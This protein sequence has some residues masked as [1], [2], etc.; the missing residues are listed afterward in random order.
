MVLQCNQCNERFTTNF[1][2]YRHKVEKHSPVIG[3]VTKSESKVSPVSEDP[4]RLK[5]LRDDSDVGNFKKYRRV[6]E[7]DEKVNGKKR[8]HEEDSNT[9]SK[10]RK[11]EIRGQKRKLPPVDFSA[12]RSRVETSGT[13]RYH[14]S[15]SER[16]SKY[17]HISPNGI[18]RARSESEESATCKRPHVEKRGKKRYRSYSSSDE[19]GSKFR[20]VEEEEVRKERLSLVERLKKEIDKW[21]RMYQRESNRNKNLQKECDDKLK[22]LDDQL[23]EMKEFD[24]D[25]ELNS[26]TKAVINSVTVEDF[27]QIRK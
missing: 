14:S 6:Q 9:P 22:Y 19:E 24:G 7:S 4:T 15:D 16:T 5:R 20:R 25:Y 26:L 1:A 17:R 12:K 18:K 27:N 8:P 11:I 3:I 10:V 23:K 13:K 21:R 2:L